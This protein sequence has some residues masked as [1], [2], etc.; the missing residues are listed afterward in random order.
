MGEGSA[1]PPFR[2]ETIVL[3]LPPLVGAL[4][5]RLHE[6]GLPVTPGRS[7]DL[8][9]ALTLVR[10]V[11]KRRLYWTIRAVLV[12]ETPRTRRRTISTSRSRLG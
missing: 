3:D 7:A 11:S 2:V 6:A 5:R 4:A 1:A 9:R 10:P 12:S 8:A